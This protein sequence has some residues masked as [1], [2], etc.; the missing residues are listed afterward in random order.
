MRKMLIRL[1]CA[2][3][4]HHAVKLAHITYVCVRCG[5]SLWTA[6]YNEG[7]GDHAFM[8]PR[9]EWFEPTTHQIYRAERILDVIEDYIGRKD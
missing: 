1:R 2:I 5:K 6:P 9:G 7:T 4:G 8:W 3:S